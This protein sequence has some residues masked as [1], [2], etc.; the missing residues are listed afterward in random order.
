MGAFAAFWIGWAIVQASVVYFT[1]H[2]TFKAVII[3]SLLTTT[4]LS[5]ASYVNVNIL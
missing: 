4:L 2:L 3:D 5:L 1:F